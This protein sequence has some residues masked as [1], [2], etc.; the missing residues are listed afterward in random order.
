MA[1]APSPPPPPP[2]RGISSDYFNS[3]PAPRVRQTSSSGHQ[4][5]LESR[6]KVGAPGSPRT[7]LF[8]RSISSQFGSPSSFR[9]ENDEVV[10][11]ELGARHLSAGF[12]GEGWPRCVYNFTPGKGGRPG[13]WRQFDPTF[14]KNK[15]DREKARNQS[16]KEGERWGRDYEL[17][18]TD[19][20][21][22][23]H[24]ELVED[25]LSRA[26]REI[27]TEHLQLDTKP[28]KAC[29]AI[30][31]LLPTPLLELVLRALFEHWQQPPSIMVLTTPIL[32]TV[33]AGLRCALV[34]DV[35]WEETVVTGIGE[36]REVAQRRSVRAGRDLVREMRKVLGDATDQSKSERKESTRVSFAEAEEVLQR[37]G[38]CRPQSSGQSEED[39][40]KNAAV[41]KRIPLPS[42][43]LE[44]PFSRLSDP[45]DTT[46][47]ATGST[48]ER[49]DAHELPLP[50]LAYKALLALPLDL[51]S[52]C[53]SRI[54]LTGGLSHLPGLKTRLLNELQQL[55]SA[56]GW[57]AV[58]SYGSAQ[59]H[60]DRI[61][62]ERSANAPPP[63]NTNKPHQPPPHS[64][65]TEEPDSQ[66][67]PPISLSPTK[68]PLQDSVPHHQRVHDDIKDPITNKAERHT[69]A[70]K[71]QRDGVARGTV[72]G[73]ETLGP[74]T[75]ASLVVGTM[76][77]KG[78]H[79]VEREEFLRH[80]MR[81]GG[82]L[83]Y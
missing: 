81:D 56:R 60:H 20:R 76:R 1:S 11:Y 71:E 74:W 72:R 31:S 70:S 54:V 21:S 46:L 6:P 25:K 3:R 77:V 18:R 30:P 80:G 12:A 28:R 5:S 65:S 38:W 10:V 15:R 29:L 14:A 47:F 48:T 43:T 35:G 50:L 39:A 33:G 23:V 53:I 24:L 68:K 82:G 13:D 73:V 57:D 62:K 55:I 79:E 37:M 69:L 9:T 22:G 75:G 36:Y 45:A 16:N 51:R 63:T 59:Q 41:K 34:I 52:L 42:G 61:V 4:T 26:V 58:N 67:S 8:S 49:L 27:H 17:Y 7:P 40:S 2:S 64:S 78:V 44:V 32:A 19:L 66:S 83:L